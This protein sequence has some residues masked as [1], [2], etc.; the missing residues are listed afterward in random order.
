MFYCTLTPKGLY[1]VNI[2][3]PPP[4]IEKKIEI[5]PMAKAYKKVTFKL[6]LWERAYLYFI[7]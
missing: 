4:H 3:N 7:L 2:F 1:I 6:F 5:A